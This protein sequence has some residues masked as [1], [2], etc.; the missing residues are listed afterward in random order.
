MDNHRTGPTP[1]PLDQAAVRNPRSREVAGGGGAAAGGAAPPGADPAL[2]DVVRDA[3]RRTV[4]RRAIA[5]ASGGQR[6]ERLALC[7]QQV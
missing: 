4:Q 2:R 5:A 7:D 6:H 1:A 3:L